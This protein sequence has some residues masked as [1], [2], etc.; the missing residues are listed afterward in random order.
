MIWGASEPAVDSGPCFGEPQF[1]AV[2]RVSCAASSS[3]A[4]TFH[5]SSTTIPLH[6]P[7]ARTSFL[8]FTNRP[9]GIEIAPKTNRTTRSSRRG[10]KPITAGN[11]SWRNAMS[12]NGMPNQ[13]SIFARVHRRTKIRTR[14]ARQDVPRDN[15]RM[16]HAFRLANRTNLGPLAVTLLHFL[17][18]KC[19]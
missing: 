1:D 14:S 13:I 19:L 15:K 18:R 4:I 5:Q 2:A 11:R 8:V 3:G 10:E 7:G 16:P 12:G 17:T 9:G 6:R